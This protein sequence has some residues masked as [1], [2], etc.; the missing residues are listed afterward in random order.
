M[1]KNVWD[2]RTG[3]KNTL[4]YTLYSWLDEYW[5]IPRQRPL[6]EPVK[7]FIDDMQ[8]FTSF[9]KHKHASLLWNKTTL[10]A[11]W[12]GLGFIVLMTCNL[13]WKKIND[14]RLNLDFEV[15][16]LTWDT[17]T[18]ITCLCSFHAL[19]VLEY[20]QWLLIILQ[21]QFIVSWHKLHTSAN[22][23]IMRQELLSCLFS[24]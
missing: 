16:D 5:V 22:N 10:K 12:C 14:L 15:K 3:A 9:R 20:F 7:H 8:L 4:F 24:S 2:T 17:R 18:W 19:R 13:T 23:I 1:K 21:T 11:L 6:V